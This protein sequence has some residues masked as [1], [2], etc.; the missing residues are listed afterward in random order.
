MKPHAQHRHREEHF[1]VQY[2]HTIVVL[3]STAVQDL[4]ALTM[5]M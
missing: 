5:T 2:L 4:K 3:S 1:G